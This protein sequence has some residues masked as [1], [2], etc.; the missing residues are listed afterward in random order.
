MNPY[1]MLE[2]VVFGPER[3]SVDVILALLRKRVELEA[4]INNLRV[5]ACDEIALTARKLRALEPHRKQRTA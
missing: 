5:A 4:D 2:H 3:L 1:E